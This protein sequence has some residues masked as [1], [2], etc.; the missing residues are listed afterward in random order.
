MDI[1][2]KSIVYTY[3][4]QKDT[5]TADS[6]A[7]TILRGLGF[8]Q[9]SIDKPMNNLSGGWKTRCTIASALF[10]DPD[11]L[12][13][14]E[15]TNF[16]DLP[17][18]IWLQSYIANLDHCTV[19]SVTHD[20]DFA[21]AV[22]EHLLVLRNQTIEVFKGNVSTYERERHKKMKWMSR[23]RDA[24]EK[25]KTHIQNTISNNIRAAKKSGDDNKLKQAASRQKKLDERMGLQVSAK[26]G[27]FKLNRDLA[28]YHL[29]KRDEIDVPD[30]DP[31]VKLSFPTEPPDLRVPGSLVSLED[32][33]FTYPG[34]SSSTLEKVNL[35]IHMNQRLGMVGL[36]GAGKS[37]LVSLICGHDTPTSGIVTHHPRLR[38][39]HYSQESVEQITALGKTTPTLTALTHIMQTYSTLG[40]QEARA[41]LSG[42]G[43][44]SAVVLVPIAQLSGGQKVR[45]ALAKVLGTM[46]PHV[47]VL[48]EITTHLDSDT[49]TA[50]ARALKRYKGAIVLVSHDRWFI[51]VVVEGENAV[52]RREL[53]GEEEI[54]DSESTSESDDEGER[55]RVVL[56]VAKGR[57]KV[58]DG[59]MD[60]YE[61]I[62]QKANS[63]LAS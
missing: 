4:Q 57:V 42:F 38:I 24:Q 44:T 9:E 52:I 23:M 63:K 41:L 8:S 54:E 6:K 21:D 48:D 10:Q 58:L 39:G 29:S 30:F 25:Q 50:L 16:L 12:L 32:V 60:R 19:V 2:N 46:P 55:Q 11:I 51:R 53:D 62:A 18:I 40:E 31:P 34:V 45:L 20:R 28:G 14:D 1:I 47:L 22:A 7:R 59:G 56:R 3:I 61:E 35:S 36:N 5:S 13:L 37:T 27:R 15:P 17:S 49:I 43:L 33:S 26:G